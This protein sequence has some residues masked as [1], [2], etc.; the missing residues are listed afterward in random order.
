MKLYNARADRIA[1]RQRCYMGMDAK[2][3]SWE[4]LDKSLSADDVR[5]GFAAP[6]GRGWHLMS[7][8]TPQHLQR[9]NPWQRTL[10]TKARHS[11]PSPRKRSNS[12]RFI[13]FIRDS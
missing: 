11:T 6:S 13:R 3:S 8:R 12:Y 4:E 7:P 2:L 1:E 9:G 10:P 5:G